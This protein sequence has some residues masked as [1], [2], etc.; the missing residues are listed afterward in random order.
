MSDFVPREEYEKRHEA[1]R[2]R[3]ENFSQKTLRILKLLVVVLLLNGLLGAYLVSENSNRVTENTRFAHALQ[4][5]IIQSCN[6]SGNP[7]RKAVREFGHALQNQIREELAQSTAYEKSGAYEKLFPNFD[8]DELHRL[9]EQNEKRGLKKIDE[10]QKAV[11]GVIAI[12]CKNKYS[13]KS[14]HEEEATHESTSDPAA[15]TVTSGT[16]VV[17]L[18]DSRPVD[19]GGSQFWLAPPPGSALSV[20]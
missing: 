16:F 19:T 9:L 5:S 7:T 10:I 2:Q 1:L 20:P 18:S 8:P 17:A 6:I 4:A 11:D 13:G 3:Y 12:N 14:D 15:V